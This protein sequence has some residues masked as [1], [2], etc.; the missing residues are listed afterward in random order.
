[1]TPSARRFSR[2]R[3][4]MMWN[5][6]DRKAIVLDICPHVK[7]TS[8]TFENTIEEQMSSSRNSFSYQWKNVSSSPVL[9]FEVVTL[10][11]DPFDEPM[12]GSRML[13]AGKNSADFTPFNPERRAGMG[14]LDMDTFT[15]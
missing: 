10:Q 8:F 4:G 1:K 2:S 7:I 5:F 13:V 12:I 6:R 11:Y 9:A 15:C 14:P 3:G